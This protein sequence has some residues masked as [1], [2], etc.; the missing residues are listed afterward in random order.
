MVP[1]APLHDMGA[2]LVPSRGGWFVV[3]AREAR[4]RDGGPLG[5][6]CF[7]EA[8]SE[9]TQLGINISVLEPG[10]PMA[11]YHYEHEQEGFLIVS[12]EALLIVEGQERPLRRWD[13]VHCPPETRHVFVGAGDGA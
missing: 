7:F 11:M 5:K 13:F 8:E 4:W 3:N 1:E 9:F 12:G 2:G 6:V 10:N